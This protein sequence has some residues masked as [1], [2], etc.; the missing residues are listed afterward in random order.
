MFSVRLPRW[1]PAAVA[2]YVMVMLLFAI[3]G[4]HWLLLRQQQQSV[5]QAQRL[6]AF[7]HYEI[8]RYAGIAAKIADSEPLKQQLQQG[9]YQ[10]LNHYLQDLQQ[11]S[12]SADIYLLDPAGLVLAS[13][14]LS[15][16]QLLRRS[17]LCLS[18]LC[19]SGATRP[20]GSILCTRGHTSGRRGYYYS[21][22]VWQQQKLIGIITVKI[23]LEPIEQQQ[24][25][26]AGLNGWHFLVTG[27]S[28]EVFLSDVAAWRFKQLKATPQSQAEQERY[29]TQPLTALGQRS[30]Q[31]LLAPAFE[32]WQMPFATTDG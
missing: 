9:Q 19:Q 26:I 32:L 23:D 30:R 31:S 4:Q 3:G 2:G 27:Q 10:A 28:D 6:S 1:W 20:T 18:T 16:R 11:A 29:L 24:Q 22:P 25:A 15:V 17:Q 8:G 13:Q 5:L 21:A 12:Q 7:I 14:Q